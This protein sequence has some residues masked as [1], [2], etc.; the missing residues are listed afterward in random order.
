MRIVTNSTAETESLGERL[1]AR[2]KGGEV[3]ALFGP[4]GMGKRRL[5]A[6]LPAASAY[7]E[8]FPVRPSLWYMSMPE[9]FLF[10]ILICSA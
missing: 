8:G 1:A 3:L 9:R 10:I 6:A 4:M 5:P 7:R 2:L